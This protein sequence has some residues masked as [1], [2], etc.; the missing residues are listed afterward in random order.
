VKLLFP[1]PCRIYDETQQ[2]VRF[3]GYDSAI[4]VSFFIDTAALKLMCPN[5]ENVET[6]YL[7]AFD[8]KISRI[9][10]VAERMYEARKSRTFDI[11]LS[12][13]DF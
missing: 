9:H 2:R 12:A 1:N 3:W 11:I 4:E 7:Q 5:M 8:S 6:E 13:N 10:D